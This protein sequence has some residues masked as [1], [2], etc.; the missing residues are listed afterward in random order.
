MV[1]G[2]DHS[3]ATTS[4][5]GT[6]MPMIRINAIGQEPV[7]HNSPG[8]YARALRR[9]GATSGP[10]IIMIHGYK[11]QPGNPIHCPHRHVMSLTPQLEPWRSPSWPRQLGFGA[12]HKD[13]GLAV[14]FGWDARG[15]VWQAMTRAKQAGVAL[16]QVCQILHDQTPERPIHVIAHSMGTEPLLE[17]MHHLPGGTI[18]RVISMTGASY[19]SRA[20]AALETQ[21]GAEAEFINVTSRENDPFDFMFER[22]VA[23][24]KRGDRAIG[25]GLDAPNVVTLQLD[26]HGT[27]GHLDRLGAPI[28]PPQRRICHWSSYTR[29]GILS[30]Y[31]DI[32][33]RPERWALPVLRAGLPDTPAPRWSRLIPTPRLNVPMMASHRPG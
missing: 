25:Q 24:P 33:R 8:S 29:P 15:A 27:L 3:D 9:A 23:P 20:I 22:L 17:A 21:A 6:A 4:C 31:K 26:C 30:F 2:F 7:L 11:Y 32:L 16:A 28:A 19:R 18:G 14:A 1:I 5:G 12:G 13:E 10:V